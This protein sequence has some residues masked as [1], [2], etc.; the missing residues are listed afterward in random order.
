MKLMASVS[1]YPELTDAIRMKADIIFPCGLWHGPTKPPINK[2]LDPVLQALHQLTVSG[3][4]MNP[5][6][7]VCTVNV[8]V[9]KG[10]FDLPAKAAVLQ[11]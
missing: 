1:K 10:L 2:L 4:Q 3:V 6:D 8:K 7:G 9:V 11:W 5:P